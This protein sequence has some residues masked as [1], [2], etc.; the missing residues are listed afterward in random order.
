MIFFRRFKIISLAE[1]WS[2]FS[3]LGFNLQTHKKKFYWSEAS[4]LLRIWYKNGMLHNYLKLTIY[5]YNGNYVVPLREKLSFPGLKTHI[6][7]MWSYQTDYMAY[8]K[9]SALHLTAM[10]AICSAYDYKQPFLIAFTGLSKW[11]KKYSRCECASKLEKC[12][13][14]P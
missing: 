14:G 10:R 1:H 5:I 3:F 8:L 7:G 4:T 11:T 12:P 6:K 9:L 13:S 2:E